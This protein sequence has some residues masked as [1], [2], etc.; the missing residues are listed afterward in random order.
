MNIK[1][2]LCWLDR[3]EPDRSHVEWDSHRYTSTCLRCGA[4]IVRMRKKTW[5][6]QP[7]KAVSD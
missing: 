6:R 3:H 1:L 5:R 4:P 7:Q 2:L